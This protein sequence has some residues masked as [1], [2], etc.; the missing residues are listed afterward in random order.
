MKLT[1]F[2]FLLLSIGAVSCGGDNQKA[3]ETPNVIFVLTDDQGYGDLGFTGNKEINTPNI[4]KLSTESLNFT[5]FHSATTSAPTRSGLMTGHY[6]NTTGVWHTIQGR[7]FLDLEE[8]TIA[9]AFTASGYKTAMFGKWHLGDNYPY[10]P[11]DRG[12]QTTLTHGGG[13]VGQTPDYWDNTYFDDTYYRQDVPEK[14]E[15]YCTDVWFNEAIKFIEENQSQPFFCYIATNAPHSPYNIVAEYSDPYNNKLNVVN[16]K[17][18][19]MITNIDDNMGRLVA[20]IDELGIADNTIIVYM[21]DN[22]TSAGVVVDKTGQVTRGYNA[23]MRG[24]KGSNYEGGHRVPFLMRI[25]GVEPREISTL[26]SHI[27]FM[28]T[29]VDI[30]SL[31]IPNDLDFDGVS[32]RPLIEGQELEDRILCVD[33]QR[34]E[35]LVKYKHRCVM[36]GEWR[37]VNDSELYN[38]R[39][40]PSQKKNLAEQHPGKLER[41]NKYY[42]EWWTRNSVRADDFQYAVID[43]NS[44][45]LL[46]VHDSHT[47]NDKIPA[48]NQNHIRQGVQTKGDWCVEISQPGEYEFALQRW[49]VEAEA[50]LREDVIQGRDFPNGKPA[51]TGT[52]LDITGARLIIGDYNK[53]QEIS[54]DSNERAIKFT[55]NLKA[56]QYRLNADFKI[57]SDY[58]TAYYV[59]VTK[60]S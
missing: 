22:G 33:T 48:W 13:G 51:V 36:Q 58:Y 46:T 30:C 39:T 25:P 28:P 15:G 47:L 19:G 29:L 14:Q 49:P 42:E 4:D 41:L 23:N 60:R 26:A 18:Y 16:P 59:Y 54:K 44:E 10:R 7:S 52:A 27:D 24:T 57:G 21:S 37:L 38:L 9:D 43:P 45:N 5:D 31:T 53:T 50:A 8:Y 1:N 32:L 35:D 6:N 11:M 2:S 3:L 34:A 17:F 55:A 12:F 40:D 56:G 20:K